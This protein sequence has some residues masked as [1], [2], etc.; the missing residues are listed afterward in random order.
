MALD[1][2]L[3]LQSA[4]TKTATFNGAGLIIPYGTP[5][6]RPLFARVL[7]SAFSAAT[8]TSTVTFSI[9][10]ATDGT[11]Y[12][13]LASAQPLLASSTATSGEVYIPFVTPNAG[14]ASV[15][16]TIR[17]T[18]TFSGSGVTTP[19]MI[20]LCDGIGNSMP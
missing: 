9:D 6:N 20:Y 12:V 18:A 1:T 8:G 7:Y 14:H 11:N 10:N 17:L 16:D 13:A 4:V 3:A 2:L 5:T 19:T 15:T